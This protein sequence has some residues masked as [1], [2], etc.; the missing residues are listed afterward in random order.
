MTDSGPNCGRHSPSLV[1]FLYACSIILLVMFQN[2]SMSG[3]HQENNE[4]CVHFFIMC[5]SWATF[6]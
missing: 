4:V 2:V 5:H 6:N 3:H 1:Y